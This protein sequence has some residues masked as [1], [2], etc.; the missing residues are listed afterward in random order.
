DSQQARLRGVVGRT[1]MEALLLARLLQ[2]TELKGGV[3]QDARSAPA[4]AARSGVSTDDLQQSHP[5]RQRR[6]D[7]ATL[8]HAD[9]VIAFEHQPVRI[10]I[11]LSLADDQ[12]RCR[13]ALHLIRLLTFEDVVV[14]LAFLSA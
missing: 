1:E 14:M 13:D 4:S 11:D 5:R 12:S 10:N 9:D 2:S 8:S 7:S 6:S 3:D